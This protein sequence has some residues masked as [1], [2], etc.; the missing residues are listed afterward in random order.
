MITVHV[1][2]YFASFNYLW[3]GLPMPALDAAPALFAWLALLSIGVLLAL[4]P[5]GKVII[6]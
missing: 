1:N 3:F 2:N 5:V 6:S 4:R